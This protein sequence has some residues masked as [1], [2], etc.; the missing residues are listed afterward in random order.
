MICKGCSAPTSPILRAALAL[1]LMAG[2]AGACLHAVPARARTLFGLSLPHWAELPPSSPPPYGL[3]PPKPA[4]ARQ[5]W[6]GDCV[7]HPGLHVASRRGLSP[8]RID[9][10]L[11][12]SQALLEDRAPT[13]RDCR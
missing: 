12:A 9:S 5:H 3:R 2:A 6:P 8:A 1:A 4:A 13:R 11:Q 10:A 7:V